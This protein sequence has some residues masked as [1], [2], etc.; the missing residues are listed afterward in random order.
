[1]I[2]TTRPHPTDIDHEAGWIVLEGQNTASPVE[3]KP[4]FPQD[5][6]DTILI[7]ASQLVNR[8]DTGQ[9]QKVLTAR[10]METSP[11]LRHL[12]CL[13]IRLTIPLPKTRIVV[14][15]VIDQGVPKG[16]SPRSRHKCSQPMKHDV[17]GSLMTAQS[18]LSFIGDRC[19]EQTSHI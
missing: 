5:P 14:G 9:E 7:I 4:I 3:K 11:L 6:R 10:H 15:N 16:E 1:M 2:L 13:W 12:D 18:H 17:E 19:E 8:P